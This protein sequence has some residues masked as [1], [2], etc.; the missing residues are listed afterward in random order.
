MKRPT[1]EWLWLL[2]FLGA[3]S[4]AVSAVEPLAVKPVPHKP[5]TDGLTVAAV[6]DMVY[7]RPML[8]TVQEQPTLWTEL[9]RAGRK[10]IVDELKQA[11]LVMRAQ[12]YRRRLFSEFG[13]VRQAFLP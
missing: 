3:A 10:T 7:L 13:R 11:S 9:D 5:I 6:G 1:F 8:T 4:G 12:S 2:V